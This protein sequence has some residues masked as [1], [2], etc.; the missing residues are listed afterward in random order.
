MHS[1]ET[2]PS[3]PV[4]VLRSLAFWVVFASSA[5]VIASLALLTF[6]FPFNVRYRF[7]RTWAI[8]NLWWLRITCRLSYEVRGRENIPAGPAIIMCKHQ[9]TWETLVLQEIFPPQVWVLKRELMRVPFFGWG[10]AL[11]EPIAI[12]RDAGRKAVKQ[13]IEE[14]KARLARGRWVVIFP[15]GTRIAP[16]QRGRYRQGGALLA[17][18]TAMPVVP[19]AHNA[20]E[21]WPRH[22][23]IKRPGKIQLVIGPPITSEGRTA[24][25]ILRETE[26][27]IEGVM[28]EISAYPPTDKD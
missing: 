23:F 21:F 12:N 15:E 28:S 1:S 11:L 6:P 9:S 4:L 19:V 3:T 14:G 5:I 16:G 24:P 2:T 13:L 20:G 7:V 27:W 18:K 8:L 25:T 26:A 22:G 10:L 17:E